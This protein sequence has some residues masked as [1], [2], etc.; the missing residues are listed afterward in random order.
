MFPIA[1]IVAVIAT[2]I[3]IVPRILHALIVVYLE[4]ISILHS[5]PRFQSSARVPSTVTEGV[6]KPLKLE[7]LNMFNFWLDWL[8]G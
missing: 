2:A 8:S 1:K 6:P 7:N 4:R 5:I 3:H